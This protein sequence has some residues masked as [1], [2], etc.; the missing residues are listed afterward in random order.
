[1][2]GGL[3][4][5]RDPRRRTASNGKSKRCGVILYTNGSA[6]VPVV[7][8]FAPDASIDDIIADD[9]VDAD[10]ILKASVPTPERL[11]KQVSPE[12]SSDQ[13]HGIVD[14]L[15]AFGDLFGAHPTSHTAAETASTA[16]VRA[17]F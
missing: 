13:Q 15:V 1:M 2:S 14:D 9:I 12:L 17:R 6:V 7:G 3:N 11:S 8:T 4:T 16:V 5:A 10:T